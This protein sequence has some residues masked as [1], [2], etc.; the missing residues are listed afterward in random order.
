MARAW[1]HRCGS[2]VHRESRKI[3]YA[4]TPVLNS[5]SLTKWMFPAEG[6]LHVNFLPDMTWTDPGKYMVT[7]LF[8]RGGICRTP[9]QENLECERSVSFPWVP[10]V[11]YFREHEKAYKHFSPSTG[12]SSILSGTG[13]D[14][15]VIEKFPRRRAGVR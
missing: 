14:E 12:V 1:S 10:E 4:G 3:P 13:R 6:K 9:S 2:I 8:K 7:V 5:A 15:T 11:Q